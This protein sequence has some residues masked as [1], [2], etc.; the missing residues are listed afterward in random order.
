MCNMFRFTLVVASLFILGC[1]SQ[2]VPSFSVPVAITVT[3]E[4]DPTISYPGHK[5]VEIPDA[6][7]ETFY[8]MINPTRIIDGGINKSLH[9]LYATIQIKQTDGT[10]RKLYVR[11]MGVNPA[12]VSFDDE[13]YYYA[14]GSGPGDGANELR[15]LC[16]KLVGDP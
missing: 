2:K 3:L 7:V 6:K 10:T 13:H 15:R 1:P 14:D 12:A 11:C 5:N 8:Q 9:A 4:P 16:T